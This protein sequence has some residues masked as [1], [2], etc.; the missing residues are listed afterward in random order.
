MRKRLKAKTAALGIRIPKRTHKALNPS[1][2]SACHNARL[3]GLAAKYDDTAHAAGIK[4]DKSAWT[5]SAAFDAA[6]K[7]KSPFF[8]G[9]P[10]LLSAANGAP[11][12]AQWSLQ[13]RH[14][15]ETTGH[16]RASLLSSETETISALCVIFLPLAPLILRGA[17]G[18]RPRPRRFRARN[19]CRAS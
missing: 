13:E 17:L 1:E 18:S 16:T 19:K 5:P 14:E 8:I 3:I 11:L 10:R 12:R 9:R 7:T 6:I 4:S 2:L 15:A